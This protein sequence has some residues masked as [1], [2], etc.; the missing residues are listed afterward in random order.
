M[1]AGPSIDTVQSPQ[2][3][4][5]IEIQDLGIVRR[6]RFTYCLASKSSV[7]GFLGTFLVFIRAKIFDCMNVACNLHGI[8]LYV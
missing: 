2:V 3:Q 7:L 6:W 5:P 1:S 4:N 8:R